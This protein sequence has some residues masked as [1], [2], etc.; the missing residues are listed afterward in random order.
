MTQLDKDLL[1]YE[2]KDKFNQKRWLAYAE[3]PGYAVNC[4]IVE[5]YAYNTDDEKGAKNRNYD[6]Y[7]ADNKP[8][9]DI[10]LSRRLDKD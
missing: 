9:L 5:L 1:T 3:I 7:S 10:G 2:D 6:K 4:R 8:F